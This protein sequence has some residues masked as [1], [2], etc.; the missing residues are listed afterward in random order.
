M[1]SQHEFLWLLVFHVLYSTFGIKCHHIQ[2]ILIPQ[3]DFH[4]NWSTFLDCVN[5]FLIGHFFLKI[6]KVPLCHQYPW[7]KVISNLLLYRGL[8]F[9]FQKFIFQ[10]TQSIENL[11][12]SSCIFKLVSNFF[13][14]RSDYHNQ[15]IAKMQHL[16]INK[17]S[18][19]A[20]KMTPSHEKM[21]HF[22]YK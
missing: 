1:E 20:V 21:Q 22:S 9:Y 7:R 5:L 14:K 2:Y 17:T 18:K 6:C 16:V 12:I 10:E 8:Y 4:H 3:H 13:V 19:I 15:L 11:C